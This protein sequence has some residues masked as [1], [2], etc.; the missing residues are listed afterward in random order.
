MQNYFI[1]YQRY[2]REKRYYIDEKNTEGNII[3]W[4][5][6]IIFCQKLLNVINQI[7][8]YIN[9]EPFTYVNQTCTRKA[10]AILFGSMPTVGTL[11]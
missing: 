2:I 8:S 10:A 11:Q 7:Y 3:T 5:K 6:T 1:Y 4:E 9:F